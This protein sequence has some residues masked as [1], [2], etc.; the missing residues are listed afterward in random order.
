MMVQKRLSVVN[1]VHR[2]GNLKI[3]LRK[4]HILIH[5]LASIDIKIV[6]SSRENTMMTHLESIVEIADIAKSVEEKVHSRFVVVDERIQ[7]HH[8]SL[9][10]IRRLIRQIL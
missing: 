3:L 1:L 10:G 5:L 2:D 8:V 4:G 7:A 9:L 6:L